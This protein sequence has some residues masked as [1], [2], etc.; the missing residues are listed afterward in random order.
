VIS[1]TNVASSKA[2]ATVIF[3]HPVN[4]SE[5]LALLKNTNNAATIKTTHM[6]THVYGCFIIENG[7]SIR[8]NYMVKTIRTLWN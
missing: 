3:T 7:L 4:S 1:G 2:P 6:L 8:Q 5:Y